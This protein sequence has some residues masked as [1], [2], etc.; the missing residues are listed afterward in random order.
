MN[1]Q[2]LPSTL[3]NQPGD[4]SFAN[5]VYPRAQ[6]GLSLYCCRSVTERET[7]NYGRESLHTQLV[8]LADQMHKYIAVNHFYYDA[9]EAL[10][11]ESE[12]VDGMNEYSY[13]GLT[14]IT[15]WLC[16]QDKILLQALERITSQVESITDGAPDAN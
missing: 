5:C 4:Q 12:I 15:H 7:K 10:F 16:D 8:T 6:L 9:V 3:K 13:Y 2:H 11:S 14:L 1:T